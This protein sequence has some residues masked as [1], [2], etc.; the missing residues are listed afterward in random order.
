MMAHEMIGR[1]RHARAGR[2]HGAVAPVRVRD[3]AAHALAW[4]EALEDAAAL[5]HDDPD[6][7]AL[8]LE[9]ALRQLVNEWYARQGL[10][11]PAAHD[12]L[13]DLEARDAPLAWRLRLALRAPHVEARLAHARGLEQAIVPRAQ[14]LPSCG[15]RA[16]LAGGMSE[17]RARDDVGARERPAREKGLAY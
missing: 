5:L 7:A 10:R 17:R 1:G 3:D 2:P 4:R 9:G 16:E 13:A 8:A 15:A 6:A 12:L 14:P 11:V